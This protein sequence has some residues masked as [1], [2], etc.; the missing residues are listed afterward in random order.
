M[1]YHIVATEGIIAAQDPMRV[2]LVL[3]LVIGSGLLKG[4]L[5]FWRHTGNFGKKYSGS[6][7][8]K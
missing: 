5:L 2:K 7:V 1:I 3:P 6:V 8:Y 4:Q